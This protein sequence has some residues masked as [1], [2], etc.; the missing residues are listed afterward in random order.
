MN[1]SQD[2]PTQQKSVDNPLEVLSSGE[3]TVMELKRHPFGL[4]GVYFSSAVVV[5]I[6]LAAAF[7]AS[8][9]LTSLTPQDR[10]GIVIGLFVLIAI[11]L[12]YM[13]ISV[14]VYKGNRWI[15]TTD[16]ITQ[17]KQAGLFHKQ[18]SQL[19]LANLE[20]VTFEQSSVI[21]SMFHFGT[22]R[23]ETAG[24]HSKFVFPFCPAPEA[25]AKR[26]IAAHE[27]FIS[28]H[29]EGERTAQQAL[30]TVQGYSPQAYPPRG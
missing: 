27:Q 4:I 16:S 28:E 11:T 14:T 13:Y 21:Q 22:L 26:I 8:R 6:L 29:P 9:Y 12:L 10:S 1:P 17:V 18:T 19:S 25:C 23:V 20:D 5:L 30:N 3:R 2:V 15:V 7:S 24:E